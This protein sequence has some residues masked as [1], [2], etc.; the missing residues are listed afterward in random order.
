MEMLKKRSGA[1]CSFFK[2]TFF[3]HNDHFVWNLFV[4]GFEVVSGAQ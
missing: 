1:Q 2:V 3:S 4:K